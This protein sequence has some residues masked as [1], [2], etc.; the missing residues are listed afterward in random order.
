MSEQ[1]AR[2]L[3]ARVRSAIS[4]GK[5]GNL[6][7]LDWRDESGAVVGTL[8]G[9]ALGGGLV[10]VCRP[11]G[12]VGVASV[13]QVV[14]VAEAPVLAV[15]S[16]LGVAAASCG[17]LDW[18]DVGPDEVPPG[19][20]AWADCYRAAVARCGGTQAAKRAAY[21]AADASERWRN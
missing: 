20:A 18:T 2:G 7:A 9:L 16:G 11:G 8:H 15:L 10:M 1:E 3:A 14:L 6:V 12:L 21:R 13:R 19:H 5:A 4:A 17:W